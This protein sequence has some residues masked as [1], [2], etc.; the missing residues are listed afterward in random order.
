MS[1]L[2][3]Y[4]IV[5][6]SVKPVSRSIVQTDG[7]MAAQASHAEATLRHWNADFPK[8]KPFRNLATIILEAR[9]Q[10]ELNHIE[11]LINRDYTYANPSN[12]N[13]G[14]QFVNY[15]DHNPEVYGTENSI[16]TSMAVYG[17]P[18]KLVWLLDYLPLFPYKI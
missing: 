18:D 12:Q 17:D 4:A 8:D 2:R 7:R 6:R 10:K 16:L 11:G 5:A 15:F 13:A 14:A 3:I 9:D 1:E